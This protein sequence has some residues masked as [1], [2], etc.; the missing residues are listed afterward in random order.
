MPTAGPEPGALPTL[1]LDRS[2]H[3]A[4]NRGGGRGLRKGQEPRWKRREG[5]QGPG[6]P[7]NSEGRR[8]FRGPPGRREPVDEGR[9]PPR[10]AD[11]FAASSFEDLGASEDLIRALSKTGVTRPS[12]IQAWGLW[13]GA[14]GVG[15]RDSAAADGF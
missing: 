9:E 8:P 11:F 3:N 1:S 4:Y 12:H 15:W 5:P 13:G 2:G 7:G 14:L 10:P 6:P